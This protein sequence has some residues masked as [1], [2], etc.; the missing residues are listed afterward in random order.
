MTWRKCTFQTVSTS[1][2]TVLFEDTWI[3]C[4]DDVCPCA[5]KVSPIRD[6]LRRSNKCLES[7]SLL[8]QPSFQR[9]VFGGDAV[10]VDKCSNASKRRDNIRHDK[11][12]LSRHIARRCV[13]TQDL[14]KR[15][16]MKSSTFA[17]I[18]STGEVRVERTPLNASTHGR[19][20]RQDQTIRSEARRIQRFLRLPF[21]LRLGKNRIKEHTM[22]IGMK[23]PRTKVKVKLRKFST[24]RAKQGN[25][26]P[27]EYV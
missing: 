11:A 10:D 6:T 8:S 23:A 12:R 1:S 3:E 18:L 22:Y 17:E 7:S 20:P 4:L 14:R 25:A 2:V 13:S 16:D 24:L 26:S 21:E 19:A 27:P 5:Q 9:K 15:D